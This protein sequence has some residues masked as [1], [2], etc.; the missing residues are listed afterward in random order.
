L[1]QEVG[2]LAADVPGRAHHRDHRDLLC[3]LPR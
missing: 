1:Q 2:D 3:G